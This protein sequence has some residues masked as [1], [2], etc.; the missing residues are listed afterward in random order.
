MSIQFT[1]VGFAALPDIESAREELGLDD[2]D[3]GDIAKVMFHRQKQAHGDE[4]LGWDQLRLGAVSLL[5]V[6]SKTARLETFSLE[7]LP[8]ILLIDAVFQAMQSR[9]PL[10]TWGGDEEFI[11]LLLFRC[12]RHRRSASEYHSALAKGT[13]PHLDLK[14]LML[15]AGGDVRFPELNDMARRLGL[16]GMLGLSADTLWDQWLAGNKG[17]PGSFAKV[18]A[19][20]AMLLALEL[21]HLRGEC[22]LEEVS[23]VH[24]HLYAILQ[25]EPGDEGLL[26]SLLT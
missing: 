22:S 24:E 10:Y 3:E 6:T 9:P 26:E 4:R 17:A 8:E 15:P 14:R 21:L 18:Q 7:E 19:V 23:R 20:N 16:P 5:R 1:A 12:L 2:L 11:P 13:V 25:D